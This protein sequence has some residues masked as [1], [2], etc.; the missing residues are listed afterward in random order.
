MDNIEL[1][2]GNTQADFIREDLNFDVD[3]KDP[4]TKAALSDRPTDEWIDLLGNGQLKKKVIR[5]GLYGKIPPSRTDYCTLN[6]I[7]KLED[8]T[9]VEEYENITIQI[10]DVEIV[11]GL[12][13]A[14]TLMK[15]N[16]IAE[17]EVASRFAYGTLGKEPNIPSNATIWYTVEVKSI[18]FEADVDSLSINQRKEIGNKKRE[19]GNW[20]FARDEPTNAIQCYRRALDYLFPPKSYGNSPFDETEESIT[21]T[22]LQSLLEDRMKVFNN[23][24]AAQIKT[25]AYDAALKSVENVLACQPLNIKALFRKGRIL[26]LKGEH[27]L[28]YTTLLQAAKL[29]PESKAIQQELAILKEKNV[30]DAQHEKNLY[31]KMLGTHKINNTTMKKKNK[32]DTSNKLVWS[33]IGGAAVTVVGVLIYRFTS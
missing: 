28:A 30:K 7:G 20:W 2:K 29:E 11:Q 15:I 3:P 10:G 23:L 33:L 5:E 18:E 8:G 4:L 14:I 25:Q 19:R 6:I 12:D 31:R 26:H 9:I 21:D 32:N 24:T 22:E 17:V 27:S 1:Q 16:E 13:L